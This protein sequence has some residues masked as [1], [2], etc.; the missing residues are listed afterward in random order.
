[1][2]YSK[3]NLGSLVE[4][5]SSVSSFAIDYRFRN[6]GI[7]IDRDIRP[8]QA[9]YGV[10]VLWSNGDISKEHSTYVRLIKEEK[11]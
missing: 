10:T 5:Y 11:S 4:F 9:R 8:N 7:I 6:P 3:L 1:M 2:D